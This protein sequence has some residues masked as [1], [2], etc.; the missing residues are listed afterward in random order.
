MKKVFYNRDYILIFNLAIFL[1]LHYFKIIPEKL[2][3]IFLIFLSSLAT[4]PV[5]LSALK[6][7][8]N[9][10][11]SVDL[12]ASIALMAS[13]ATKEWTSAAFI[14]LM[15]ASARIFNQYTENKSRSAIKSL[16]KLR[17]KKIKIKKDNEIKEIDISEIKIGDLMIIE[18]GERVPADGIILDGEA[19]IDQSSLS[20]ESLPIAKTIGDRILS[21]TL[22]VSGSLVAKVERIGKDTTLEKIISLV[23]ESQKGKA[24]INTLAEKF[25]S[26]YIAATIILAII[27]YIFSD[28]KLLLSVLL[29]ACADD[30]AIAIPMTFLAA[31]GYAGQ[32]GVVIKG[33]HFLEELSKLKTILID[34][35]GTLTRGKLNIKELKTFGNYQIDDLLNFAA[36]LESVS[37]HPIAKAIV[38]YAKEQ[39]IKFQPPKNFKEYTGQGIIAD[40]QNQQIVSGNINFLKELNFQISEN[41]LNEIKK[42]QEKGFNITIIGC[43]KK[44]IGLLALADEIRPEIKKTIA[45]L[46]KL[47]VKNLIML[48]G[49]NE[50]VAENIAKEAGIE[51]FHANLS[52]KDK[53]NYIKK[54]LT[55][56]KPVA[57]IGDGVNDAA[58]LALSDIGIA[59]GTIGSD[60]AIEAADI[61][62]MK[63]DLKELPE[64]IKLGRYALRIAYQDFIIWGVVN[65]VGLFLIF[66]RIIG[67]EGAAAYNFITDFFPLLN[68]LKLFNLHLKIKK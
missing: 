10:K 32:R 14:N 30:I 19:N 28:I 38:A 35:T 63:D 12:L 7:I 44:I 46:K 66:N 33:G 11:I 39:K 8:K 43:D 49:D 29:V 31:I 53:L 60:A 51:N 6:S 64:M 21:S 15:L 57:M 18:T 23:E 67:P 42:L 36:M 3:E 55:K 68:S 1:F 47:G 5:I 41:E 25:A 27:I 65:I 17:P 4:L 50:K 52:P 58:A 61:A 16:L 54:Y 34:K 24:K 56:N 9:K 40:Y 22:N 26:W 2:D 48:T 59:M 13:L 62:L 37:S 45:E 20:G